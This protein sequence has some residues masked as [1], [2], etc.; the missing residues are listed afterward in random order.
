MKVKENLKKIGTC[1]LAGS[2]AASGF[3]AV[4]VFAASS[5][6]AATNNTAVN[7]ALDNADIIDYSRTGSITI[8]KY[9]S[10]SAQRDGVW[11]ANDDGTVTVTSGGQSYTVESTGEANATAEEALADYAI[12]GVEFSYVHLGDVETYSFTGGG[13]TDI[14]VVYEIDDGLAGILGLE[15]AE[16]YDMQAEGVAFP[17]DNDRLHY[18]SSQLGDAL[19]ELM[20]SG[21]TAAKNQLETYAEVNRTGTFADT[22]A[23]GYTHLDNLPLGLYL[24]VETEVPEEV[25]VTVAPWLVSLPFTNISDSEQTAQDEDTN[26][27][28]ETWLYDATCYPKDQT[29]NPT[30]DKM[31]RNAYGNILASGGLSSYGTNYVVSAFDDTVGADDAEALVNSRN[32]E[33]GTDEYKFGDTTTAS[34][35][36]ILDYIVVSK[37]PAITSNATFLTR[38]TF[39]DNLSAGLTYNKD[40][41]IAIY[42]NEADA[43]LN[44]LENA[45]MAMDLDEVRTSLGNGDTTFE[46][47]GNP[48]GAWLYSQNYVNFNVTG[49]SSG[50]SLGETTMTISFTEDGLRMINEGLAQSAD[51][52][53]YGGYAYTDGEGNVVLNEDGFSDYY[54]VLYYTVTVNSDAQV[55]LGDD[56]NPNDVNLTWER[57]SEDYTNTLEDRCY[58]YAYGVDLTK[59]FSDSNGDFSNVQFLLYNETD[60]YYVVA[61][62]VDDSTDENIYYAGGAGDVAG[63]ELGKTGIP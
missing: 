9:D 7:D 3:M 51:V 14:S 22:D 63:T 19:A 26:T 28:S 6:D 21:D 33:E 10:T 24:I 17:C 58:V 25:T 15:E 8:Y 49:N 18:D 35:G 55:V 4:P 1:V 13:N 27:I 38:Y 11:S 59:Y 43:N 40:A 12:Q 34:E 47:G 44:N 29:G 48:T 46:D 57:T 31:V 2:M 32:T 39:V 53:D 45:V 36:D 41:R 30:L 56:G 5:A 16:A 20:A 52:L 23:N 42:N 61:D 54:V 60:G 50:L 37:L 62:T